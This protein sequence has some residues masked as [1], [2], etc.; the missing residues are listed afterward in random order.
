M[1][2][3]DTDGLTSLEHDRNA[4]HMGVVVARV[5][6]DVADADRELSQTE[7]A[8][9]RS[10]NDRLRV[11]NLALR[12]RIERLKSDRSLERY[13]MIGGMALLWFFFIAFVLHKLTTLSS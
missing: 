10:S 11:E 13:L 3:F 9:L 12:T 4:M 2:S 1:G 7:F 8:K 5:V 6:E